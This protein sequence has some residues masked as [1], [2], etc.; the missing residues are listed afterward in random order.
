MRLNIKAKLRKLKFSLQIKYT[1]NTSVGRGTW[2]KMVDDECERE[3]EEEMEGDL[4]ILK[5]LG[6]LYQHERV[7]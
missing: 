3:E 6:C 2:V 4:G 1:F 7:P 5:N